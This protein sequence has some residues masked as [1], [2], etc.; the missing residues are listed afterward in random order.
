MLLRVSPS[1]IFGK[2]PAGHQIGDEFTVDGTVVNSLK[3][4]I[5]YVALSVFTSQVSQ[6]QRDGRVTS[7]LSCP[8]CSFNS[9]MENRVVFVL[10]SEEAWE[11][12]KNTRHITGEDLTVERPKPQSIIVIYV[13]GLL[14]LANTSRLNEQ[15]K[16]L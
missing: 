3:G 6:I 7:H 8:G 16:K 14:K 5:C 11:L 1:R 13:G 12:S 2:C 15:L 4:P 10:G 9:E